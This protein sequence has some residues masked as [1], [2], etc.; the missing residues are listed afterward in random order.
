MGVPARA[1]RLVCFKNIY[2]AL[3]RKE[4]E[5]IR[6]SM[7]R[8]IWPHLEG[9]FKHWLIKPILCPITFKL[10]TVCSLEG[11]QRANRKLDSQFKV[12]RKTQDF[13]LKFSLTTNK[14]AFILFR[15]WMM[16]FH[17]RRARVGRMCGKPRAK[18]ETRTR[19]IAGCG[20]LR[21]N[22]YYYGVSNRVE[23]CL[24]K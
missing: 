18:Q 16:S 23:K 1:P 7:R 11:V 19:G 14:N 4:R 8:G 3:G 21:A 24:H 17:V 20:L 9:N 6:D 15:V 10:L 12:K 2:K 13:S 22:P 5:D